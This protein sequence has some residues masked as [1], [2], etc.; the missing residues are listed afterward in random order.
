MM[1]E[2]R[3]KAIPEMQREETMCSVGLPR[4]D[5]LGSLL[6][7]LPVLTLDWDSFPIGDP[8]REGRNDY[9]AVVIGAGLGGL[10]CAAA[11]ARQGFRPLVLEQH[12]I[13]G[14]YATT[15]RRPGG[16]EFDVSLH[17]TTVGERNGIHNL[18]SGFPEIE[19]VEFVPHEA[20]YRMILPDHDIR[21]PHRDVTAYIDLLAEHFPAERD[22]IAGLIEDMRGLNE[23]IMRY[24]QAGDQINM[25]TFPQE[26]PHLFGNL[27]RTWGGMMDARLNDARLKS[28]FSALWGYFGL[29]PSRLSAFY[30]ALPTIGY[31]DEG[32]YYPIGKSQKISNAFRDFIE[33]R[34]GGGKAAHEGGHLPDR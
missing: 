4:R 34:G 24:Y 23:D 26:F 17:S 3:C 13:P 6:Y 29:P 22:G 11:F 8:D 9:D 1:G 5:F 19:E 28:I 16:F 20:L 31:L 14:G 2:W 18:I 15:F 25:M 10:S 27:N 21:V 32:G 12:F 33:E 7:G 30:Y